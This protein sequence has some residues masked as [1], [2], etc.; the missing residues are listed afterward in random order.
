[1][2]P[3]GREAEAS[4]AA[5]RQV[6]ERL[7]V[8][9]RR[10][11]GLEESLRELISTTIPVLQQVQRSAAVHPVTPGAREGLN[12]YELANVLRSIVSEE[13]ENRRRLWRAREDPDYER[14][15]REPQPLVSV[16][17]TTYGRVPALTQRTLPSILGQSYENLEV[18][19]VGDAA[20]PEIEQEVLS[21]TDSRLTYRNL[22]QRVV[23]GDEAKHWL[24][25]STMTR[26]EAVR[27]A[28]G[29]WVLAF[30]HD[31]ELEPQAVQTLISAAQERRLEVA[32]GRMREVSSAGETKSIGDFPPRP[33]EFSW[34]SALCHQGLRFFERELVAAEFGIP[35]D[36]YLLDRMLRAGVRFGM[37]PATLATYYP[38][39]G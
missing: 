2:A 8:L 26:N 30:D 35:G 20:P 36:W 16:T 6:H 4:A 27:M 23:V 15:Y 17:V 1:V 34:G 39:R 5:W 25:G 31:D 12:I 33:G 29:L 22:T 21:L 18:I 32:Y 11:D 37:V 3:P 7:D 10:M 19:V 28:R 38:S 14:A 24:V 9:D 13:A